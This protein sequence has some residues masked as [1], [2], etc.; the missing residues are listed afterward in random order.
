MIYYERK[1]KLI[2][3]VKVIKS[4]SLK[5]AFRTLASSMYH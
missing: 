3:Y 4:N 5:H 1:R 2:G